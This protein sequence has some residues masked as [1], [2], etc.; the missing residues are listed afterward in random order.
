MSII[1]LSAS[2]VKTLKDCSWYF[3]AKYCLKLPDKT[4]LGAAIGSCVHDLFEILGSPKKI[5][6]AQDF[7]EADCDFDKFPVIFRFLRAKCLKSNIGLYDVDKKSN[8]SN[9]GLIQDMIRVG[10]SSGFFPEEGETNLASELYFDICHMDPE[11]KI[12]GYMDKLL[13]K[14]KEGTLIVQDFKSSKMVFKGEELDTNIQAMIYSLAAHFL[15]QKQKLPNFKKVIIQFIFLR[16]AENPY[17]NL[18]FTEEELDGFKHYL[19]YLSDIISN[20]TIEDAQ[21]DYAS[22]DPARRWKCSTKSGWKCPYKDKFEYWAVVDAEGRVKQTLFE[23]DYEVKSKLIELKDGEKWE[24]LA[25]SGCP[26]WNVS[27]EDHFNF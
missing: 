15:K 26:A 5:K 12:V 17:Q 3:W 16:F 8:K 4:N 27:G 6:L 25:Y 14:E 2:K 20:F 11:F 9:I 22:N 10:L 23:D 24:K 18:E 19:A 13:F 21:A 1:N 7:Y